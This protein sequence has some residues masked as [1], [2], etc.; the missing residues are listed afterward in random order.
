MPETAR[1]DSSTTVVGDVDGDRIPEIV[2][3]PGDG[4]PLT[5]VPIR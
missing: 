1:Y 3:P 4:R 5:V 2:L